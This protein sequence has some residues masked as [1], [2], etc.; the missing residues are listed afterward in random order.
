MVNGHLELSIKA[1]IHGYCI[2]I[3]CF[4]LSVKV[5]VLEEGRWALIHGGAVPV[6]AALLQSG[7]P[8]VRFNVTDTLRHL[9]SDGTLNHHIIQISFVYGI[10]T[11]QNQFLKANGLSPLASLIASDYSEI[12]EN[13]LHSLL[14]LSQDGALVIYWR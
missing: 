2:T 11:V 5:D 8:D 13:V 3:Y 14:Y 7:D 9:L 10:A 6:L 1:P 12:M 4:D